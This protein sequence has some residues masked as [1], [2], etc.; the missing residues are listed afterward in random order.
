MAEDVGVNSGLEYLQDKMQTIANSARSAP[1]PDATTKFV[2]DTCLQF[3]RTIDSQKSLSEEEDAAPKLQALI[4]LLEQY[5]R[6][7]TQDNSFRILVFVKAARSTSNLSNP[8]NGTG[9]V[10]PCVCRDLRP[11]DWE[12]VIHIS[13]Q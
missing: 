1:Q 4:K 5:S 12:E 10:R 9:V 11:W 8:Q 3:I 6:E 2:V 13:K 7:V